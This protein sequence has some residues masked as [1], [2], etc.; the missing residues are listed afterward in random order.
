MFYLNEKLETNRQKLESY[1]V[2][3]LEELQ[4]H[5]KGATGTQWVPVHHLELVQMIEK[6]VTARGYTIEREELQHGSS[7]KHPNGVNIHNLFGYFVLSGNL[8][9]LEGF[10]RVLAF[11]HSNV[12]DFAIKFLSGA[13]VTLCS[14]GIAN[15]EYVIDRKHTAGVNLIELISAGIDAWEDQQRVLANLIERLHEIELTH[16]EASYILV[17]AAAEDIISSDK[18]LKVWN[19]Y[20]NPAYEEWRHLTGWC[21][22]QATTQCAKQWGLARQDDAFHK[23]PRHIVDFANRMVM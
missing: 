9:H 16:E 20:L 15:G 5:R 4:A 11:R 3:T 7:R 22:L 14:N 6:V 19:E 1:M 21:L 13:K 2:P 8:P 10:T 17:T 18:I 12:Q 23:M